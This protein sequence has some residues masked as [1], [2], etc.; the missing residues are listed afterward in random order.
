MIPP[1]LAELLADGRAIPFSEYVEVAL[2]DPVDGFYATGGRAGGSGDFLTSPEVGPL[3]GALLARWLDDLWIELG[4][5]DPFVV[6]EVGAGPGTLARTLRVAHPSCAGAMTYVLV[7]R[8]AP[9]R[10][11]HADHLPG[12]VGER[13]G[14][15]LDAMLAGPLSGSGPV[16]ASAEALPT[17]LVGAVIANE[18]IDNLAFDIVRRIDGEAEQIAVVAIEDDLDLAVVPID[19]PTVIRVLSDAGVPEGAWTPWPSAG[20]AWVADALA[21]IERGRLLLVDYGAAS[22]ELARR[23]DLGWMRT[24]RDH[25]RG[26]HPLDRPGHQDI[27]C[28]VAVDLLQLDR[29]ATRVQTQAEWLVALGL[30]AL[31]EEGRQ[32]W[33]ERAHAPDVT[34]LRARSR[35]REAE[36]LT[37]PD[38]LGA[39]VVL[40]WDVGPASPQPTVGGG[41]GRH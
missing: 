35:V 9:Q 38:G 39:F 40:E 31:V 1:A 13:S 33:A 6:V 2:Y 32:T 11:L 26:G 28:D 18:L 20:R 17:A 29:P 3:Y 7:E 24:Y 30:D 4:R 23:P 37:D 21:R 25:D 10:R 8:S 34:A 15:D 27:T 16:F 41:D 14:G 5:P 12:W 22:A 19:D 36:A